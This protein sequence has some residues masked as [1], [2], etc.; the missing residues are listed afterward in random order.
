MLDSVIY[1]MLFNVSLCVFKMETGEYAYFYENSIDSYLSMSL[2]RYWWRLFMTSQFQLCVFAKWLP[3]LPGLRWS[4]AE[5]MKQSKH[6]KSELV[7]WL[8]FSSMVKI[9][10]IIVFFNK[11]LNIHLFKYTILIITGRDFIIYDQGVGISTAVF[12]EKITR[13]TL[14]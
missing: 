10:V 3:G 9:S 7:I 5:I 6:P 1:N 14:I 13:F 8:N 2:F 11:L 4:D 12:N